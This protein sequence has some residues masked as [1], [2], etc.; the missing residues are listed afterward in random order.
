M[1]AG[2]KVKSVMNNQPQKKRDR[3]EENDEDSDGVRCEEA[4]VKIPETAL[5]HPYLFLPFLNN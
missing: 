2:I 5:V 1:L 3:D 4:G